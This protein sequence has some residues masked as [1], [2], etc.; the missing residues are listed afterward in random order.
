ME[1]DQLLVIGVMV[2]L[3]AIIMYL[4]KQDNDKTKQIVEMAKQLRESLPE[5]GAELLVSGFNTID[6]RLETEFEKTETPI[7]N[8][9]WAH[10]EERIRSTF[11]LPVPPN[12]PASG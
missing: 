11:N 3:L 5:W 1:L 8:E 10:I 6:A 2:V 12:T 4:L 9:L 7:D